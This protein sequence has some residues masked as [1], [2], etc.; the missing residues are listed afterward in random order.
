MKVIWCLVPGSA[1]LSPP[2]LSPPMHSGPAA[3]TGAATQGLSHEVSQNYL[4]CLYYG[5][6]AESLCYTFNFFICLIHGFV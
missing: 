6:L 5:I 2:M 3:L 1:E 4:S